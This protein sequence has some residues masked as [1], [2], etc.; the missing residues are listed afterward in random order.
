MIIITSMK[1]HPILNFHEV[2]FT[3]ETSSL[4]ALLEKLKVAGNL[5]RSLKNFLDFGNVQ[6]VIAKLRNEM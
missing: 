4:I 1:T 6:N 5:D 3:G 2:R